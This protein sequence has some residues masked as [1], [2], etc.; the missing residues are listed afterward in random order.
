MVA[1][2][3]YAELIVAIFRLLILLIGILI[4]IEIIIKTIGK[5]RLATI[6]FLTSFIPSIFYTIGRILNIEALFA[7]G[8]LLSLTF[9]FSTSALILIGLIIMDR[10]INELRGDRPS[11]NKKSGKKKQKKEKT[12][13]FSRDKNMRV[14]F[15]N[16]KKKIGKRIKTKKD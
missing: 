13:Y 14:S 6:F 7:T 10:V 5:L 12:K 9:N 15:A 11:K 4:C 16:Y 3:Y 1:S 8:K 2:A